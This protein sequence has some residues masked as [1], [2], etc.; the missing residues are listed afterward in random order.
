[1]RKG[2]VLWLQ[3]VEAD[4]VVARNMESAVRAVNAEPGSAEATT[5][6]GQGL[7]QT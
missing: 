3:K 7:R 5:G 1:M 4:R 6:G 2:I